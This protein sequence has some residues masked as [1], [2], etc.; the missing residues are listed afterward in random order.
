MA[1]NLVTIED[2]GFTGGTK[3]IAQRYR[4]EVLIVLARAIDNIRLRAVS[5]IIPNTAG[6]K[7][8]NLAAKRQPSHPTKLTSRT[9]LLIQMLT[10][11]ASTFGRGSWKF[12]SK[13]AT[14]NT[15]DLRGITRVSS[16]FN[17][18]A[19]TYLA[20]LRVNVK[21]DSVINISGGERKK[22]QSRGHRVTR[23]QKVLRFRH[24]TGIRGT[25]RP[26][27][28]PATKREKIELHGLM[29][30]RLFALKGF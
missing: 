26:F 3:K 28:G 18:L 10:D 24:E 27:V 5:F 7:A 23:Q 30:Q 14:L 19:E 4:R 21:S 25:A 20:M 12:G 13:R 22:G 11:K 9:G 16:G 6:T 2:K 1:K 29:R 8:P 15:S 17:T